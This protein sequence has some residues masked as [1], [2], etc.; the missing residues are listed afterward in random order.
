MFYF[1]I[2]YLTDNSTDLSCEIERSENIIKYIIVFFLIMLI[3]STMFRQ[4][5]T[6]AIQWV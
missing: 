3:K 5:Y 6:N 4:V 2:K 1:A